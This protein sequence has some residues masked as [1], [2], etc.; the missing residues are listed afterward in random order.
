MITASFF[1]QGFSP[2]QTMNIHP[3]LT[4]LQTVTSE[5]HKTKYDARVFKAHVIA[6][7]DVNFQ[8]N[9]VCEAEDEM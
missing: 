1:T 2:Q 8:G 9:S 3:S 4:I 6:L 5:N 7:N